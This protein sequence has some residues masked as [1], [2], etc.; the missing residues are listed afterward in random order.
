M[1]DVRIGDLIPETGA[2]PRRDAIHVAVFPAQASEEIERGE[3]VV[4]DR[5]GWARSASSQRYAVGIADPFLPK[6][7]EKGDK[8]WVFMLPGTITNL[9]H[10]WSHPNIGDDEETDPGYGSSECQGCQ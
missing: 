2:R 3:F 6:S 10:N 7:V 5:D 9:R 8:F 4:V 1:S